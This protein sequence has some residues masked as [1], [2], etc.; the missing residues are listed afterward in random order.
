MKPV[1]KRISLAVGLVAL[2]AT[3]VIACQAG[4]ARMLANAPTVV[5][6]VNLSEVLEKLDQRSQAAVSLKAMA[7]GFTAT[8]K[9][10]EDEMTSVQKEFDAIKDQPDNPK[11]AE[12]REKAA[13]MLLD[14]QAWMRFATAKSDL[15]E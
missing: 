4:A 13:A 11:V 8:K 9:I 7:D 3:V 1:T 10:R 14:Y 2:G 6:S 15:E 12:L 5:V